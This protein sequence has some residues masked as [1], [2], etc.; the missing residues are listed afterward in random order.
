ML[1]DYCSNTGAYTNNLIW[2]YH[3]NK[4][5]NGISYFKIL[6]YSWVDPQMSEE[7]NE[8]NNDINEIINP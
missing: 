7:N 1:E 3:K 4:D 8:E 6:N 5:K 2:K